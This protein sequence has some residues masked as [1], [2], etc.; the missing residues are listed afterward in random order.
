MSAHRSSGTPA[1]ERRAKK[2]RPFSIFL[3]VEVHTHA[4]ASHLDERHQ[5]SA[6]AAADL[7]DSCVPVQGG[8]TGHQGNDVLPRDALLLLEVEPP[9]AVPLLHARVHSTSGS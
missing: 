4:R 2:L 6:F 8:V 1:S 3:R 7:E 5:I 9:V